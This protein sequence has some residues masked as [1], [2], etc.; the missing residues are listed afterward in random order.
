[1]D[2]HSQHLNSS[3]TKELFHNY[4]DIFG[5]LIFAALT[6]FLHSSGLASW[7]ALTAA[8]S[9][10]LFS[11]TVSE[12]AE[13]LAEKL[14]EPYGSF[15]LTLS[16]VIVEII[17]LFMIIQQA[18]VSPEAIETVKGSLISVVIVD[19]NVLLGLAVFIGGLTFKEQTHNEDTSSSYTTILLVTALIL[20]IPSVLALSDHTGSTLLQS[21]YLISALLFVFYIVI[22]IFQTRTHIHFFKPTA[23]SRIFRYRRRLDIAEEEDRDEHYLFAN[24]GVKFNIMAIF[25]LL[26][27]IGLLSEIFAQDGVHVLVTT[28]IPVGIAG[29]ILALISV[30]PELFTAIKAAKNDQIQRVINIAMGASTVSI[31]LTVPVLILLAS[32]GH[33]TMTLDFNPLQVGALIFTILLAWKTTTDGETD[34]LKG[35]SH[36]IFFL[37]YTIIAALY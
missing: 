8:I 6:L 28:G 16:A 24:R 12:I 27:V 23:R 4:W 11:V 29:L 1:M 30:T 36:L 15:V 35:A 25:S 3:A 17:L 32:M 31:L 33:I 10:S 13:I 2:S 19:I 22:L 34:Y 20:L 37:G 18:R 7:A 26:F 9:I 21:T 5:G 14:D